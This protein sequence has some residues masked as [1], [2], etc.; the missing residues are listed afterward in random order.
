MGRWIAKGKSPLGVTRRASASDGVQSKGNPGGRGVAAC[1]VRACGCLL[2][3]SFLVASCPLRQ[4]KPVGSGYAPPG[5]GL[6]PSFGSV[7]T[8]ITSV[9]LFKVHTSCKLLNLLV[10]HC[11]LDLQLPFPC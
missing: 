7:G 4:E 1:G 5:P 10:A 9:G 2:A 11:R 3:P 6:K 8:F